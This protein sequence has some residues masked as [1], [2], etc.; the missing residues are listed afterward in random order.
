M[1]IPIQEVKIC[2]GEGHAL[3]LRVTIRS[4]RLSTSSQ[5]AHTIHA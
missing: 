2:L 3:R 1:G 4:D 5:K